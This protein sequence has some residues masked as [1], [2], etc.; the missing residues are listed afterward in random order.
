VKISIEYPTWNDS[1]L[2]AG[3]MIPPMV[4]LDAIFA[5]FQKKVEEK[6]QITDE[7]GIAM[8]PWGKQRYRIIAKE[9]ISQQV[10]VMQE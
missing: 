9:P 8:K 6:F 10:T 2:A 5:E 7:N 4:T 1:W 3:V